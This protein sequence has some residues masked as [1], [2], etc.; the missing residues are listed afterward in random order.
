MLLKKTVPT[1][2]K[3]PKILKTISR[4][5][6]TR[7]RLTDEERALSIASARDLNN[8]PPLQTLLSGLVTF[9]FG[10]FLY[11]TVLL[12]FLFPLSSSWKLP[13]EEEVYV[14]QRISGVGKTI[15][16]GGVSLLTFFTIFVGLGVTVLGLRVGYG[17]VTGELNAEGSGFRVEDFGKGGGFD[18]GEQFQMMMGK[19]KGKGK[20]EDDNPFGY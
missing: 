20:E 13:G 9:S 5:L 12:S 17:V 10:L 15:L 18:V 2:R 3:K 1:E 11:K 4:T 8:I 16:Y 7:P 14:I 19:K 6:N